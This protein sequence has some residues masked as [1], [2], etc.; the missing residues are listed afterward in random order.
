MA[1]DMT[2][3]KL[4]PDMSAEDRE[5]LCAAMALVTPWLLVEPNRFALMHGDYRLDNMLFDPDRSRITVVDWQTLGVGLPARDL[6]YFTATSLLPETRSAIEEEL[7]DLVPPRAVGL[8]RNGLRP[9]QLLAGLPARHA[10]GTVSHRVGMRVRHVDGKRRRDDAGDA[11]ARL[12][13]DPRTE[14]TGPAGGDHRMSAHFPE[15]GCDLLAGQ[16]PTPTSPCLRPD[17]RGR[18]LDGAHR[19]QP[20]GSRGRSTITTRTPSAAAASSLGRVIS[21][22]LFLV[23]RASMACSRNKASSSS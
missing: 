3:D 11:A 2:L 14:G 7:V 13:G 6:A 18:L 16:P 9:G 8:R 12:S 10:A 4:G 21:P 17:P 1:A 23:T 20:S 22:P 19:V 5:T 15:L